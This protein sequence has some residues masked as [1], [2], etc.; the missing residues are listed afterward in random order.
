MRRTIMSR[1]NQIFKNVLEA[2]QEA[3]EI[4]GVE[5]PQEYLTLMDDIRH[6]AVKRFMNC[7]DNM[8]VER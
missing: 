5:D 3:D 8:E 2:M 4:E 7:V 6:E 1:A